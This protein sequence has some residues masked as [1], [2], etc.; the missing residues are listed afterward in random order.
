MVS[1]KRIAGFLME[2]GCSETGRQRI[3]VWMGGHHI[4]GGTNGEL[5][6]LRRGNAIINPRDNL[7]RDHKGF[8][9]KIVQKASIRFVILSN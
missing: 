8:D 4:G 5:V 6:K 9:I 7:L 1:A 3:V 2:D